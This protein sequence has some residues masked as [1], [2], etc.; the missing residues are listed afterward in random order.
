MK[1][2][3][4]YDVSDAM[5]TYSNLAEDDHDEW[6]DVATYARGDYVISTATHTV[7]RSLLDS[8]TDND[9]DLEQAA[10]ADPLVDDP[11]PI[12]WQ[13][14]SA[15][16]KW[17]LFDKKPSNQASGTDEIIVRLVNATDFVTGVGLVGVDAAEVSISVK[18]EPG[19]T[20]VYSDTRPML[21]DSMVGDW[22]EYYFAPL[23]E[24][25]EVLFLNIPPY[26]G[27][28]VEITITRTGG[29]PK[30]G[31]I[32]LGESRDFGVTMVGGTRFSGFDFSF[33]EQDEFGDLITVVRAAT[34]LSDFDAFVPSTRAIVFDRMMRDLRGG[35]PAL[36]I[37]DANTS[38]AAT[39]YGFYRNYSLAY[40][41]ADYGIFT[42]SVQG[43]V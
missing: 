41:S 28:E 4:P 9:P 31:Q 5:L 37:G 36:W 29:T 18:D 16:N 10:L 7:Y 6:S 32:I 34:R 24:T 14:I 23:V 12:Y 25:S 11:S 39:N 22:Y 3:L 43:I 13:V 1:I 8:N 27:A 38:K 2:I 42:I 17:K 21:D 20:A 15:T 30:C 19:G 26:V 40:Q 33:V 35:R